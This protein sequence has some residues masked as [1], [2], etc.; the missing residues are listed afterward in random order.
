MISL[1]Y[2]NDLR[3]ADLERNGGNIVTNDLLNTTVLISLF[4]HRR[5]LP[6]DVL[7]DEF[8]TERNGWWA[9]AFSEDDSQRGSRMWLLNRSKATQDVANQAKI[10]AEE[11]LEWLITIGVAKSIIVETEIKKPDILAFKVSILRTDEKSSKWDAVWK[12]HL[13]EL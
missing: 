8:S 10:Y 12:A 11:A 1:V 7:P 3:R 6:D 9:D 13:A 4:T 2:D 5:A